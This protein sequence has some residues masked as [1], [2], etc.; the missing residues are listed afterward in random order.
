MKFTINDR[1]IISKFVI[2]ELRYFLKI[3]ENAGNTYI[4]ELFPKNGR[5]CG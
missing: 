2:T 4:V 3:D 5:K 1:L